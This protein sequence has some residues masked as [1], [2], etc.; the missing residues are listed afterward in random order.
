MQVIYYVQ[1]YRNGEPAQL[2]LRGRESEARRAARL[3]AERYDGVLVWRQERD[4]DEGYYGEP[5]V[6][7]STGDVPSLAHGLAAD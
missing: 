2:L 6:L 3:L 7:G 4:E 1:G 5:E